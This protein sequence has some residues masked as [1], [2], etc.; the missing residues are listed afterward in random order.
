M[1]LQNSLNA[2][3]PLSAAQG[4]LGVASP[5]AHG[6]LVAEGASAATPIVLT[7]GQLLIG[8]TGADP[9]AATITAGAGISV[10]VGAGTLT[11]D[12]TNSVQWNSVSGT[13]Q[14]MAVDS[15]YFANNAGA[16]TL[17]LPTTAAVGDTIVVAQGSGGGSWTIAQ[18]NLQSI[19]YGNQTTTT[20]TGGSL[21]STA[22]GDV[23]TLVCSVA[24][25]V[26]KV[27]SSVGNLAVA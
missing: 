1:A 24:N 13:T 14:A 26:F 4:G 12:S 15:G 23:V 2:P 25:T 9:V 18:N 10:T 17:T 5:T 20:G 3:F 22:N 7:N 27:L 11:I 6:I 8:S 16:T 19:V 21:A